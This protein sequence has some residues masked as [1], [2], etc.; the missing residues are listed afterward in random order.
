MSQR[1]G[2]LR[3]RAVRLTVRDDPDSVAEMRTSLEQVGAA[4][5]LPDQSV[6]DLKVAATEAVANALRHPASRGKDV[7][8]ILAAHEGAL[9]IEVRNPGPFQL[10]DG[11][12]PERGRG[13]PLMVALADEVEFSATAEGMRVRLRKLLERRAA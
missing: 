13:L 12:D 6:F 7:A 9:E 3:P 10:G 4:V 1:N 8:V 5:G 2:N 11:M